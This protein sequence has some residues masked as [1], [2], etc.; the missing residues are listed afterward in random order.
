MGCPLDPE[1]RYM[2][3]ILPMS[4]RIRL[5][6]WVKEMRKTGIPSLPIS[7]ASPRDFTICTVEQTQSLSYQNF[8]VPVVAQYT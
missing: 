7:S 8:P 1:A 3:S 4:V 2:S 6:S 5:Y